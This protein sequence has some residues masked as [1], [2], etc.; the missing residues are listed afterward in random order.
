MSLLIISEKIIE[1]WYNLFLKCLMNLAVNPFGP[2]VFCFIN[3][4]IENISL[5]GKGLNSLSIVSYV[6]YGK[7][8][9]WRTGPF[10]LDYQICDHRVVHSI[11]L[12]FFN[13]YGICSD[14]SILFL[15]LVINHISLFSPENIGL[16]DW[17]FF[18]FWI[19]I[20]VFLSPS[21]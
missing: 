20:V 18:P 15:I 1:N 14:G 3:L 10:Y 6:S 16:W 7:L 5:I 13:I 21:I 11:S 8:C 4:I 19:V 2:G 12:L 17:L 9:L